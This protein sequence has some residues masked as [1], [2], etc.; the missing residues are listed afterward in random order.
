[1][2]NLLYKADIKVFVTKTLKFRVRIKLPYL[3]AEEVTVG[4]NKWKLSKYDPYRELV[5]R[6]CNGIMITLSEELNQCYI[7]SV[8][9]G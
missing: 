9:Q 1:M 3:P 7:H 2:N 8:K 4:G 5:L 6:K